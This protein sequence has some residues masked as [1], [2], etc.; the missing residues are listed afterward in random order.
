MPGRDVTTIKDLI[1]Y[2][3]AEIIARS[4]FS[5][6]DGTTAKGNFYAFIKQAFHE[7]HKKL[8]TYLRSSLTYPESAMEKGTHCEMLK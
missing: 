3:Y 8:L 1:Y 5:V 4:A 2:Q 7:L 6:S